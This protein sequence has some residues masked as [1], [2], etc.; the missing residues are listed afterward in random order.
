MIFVRILIL[1]LI[2]VGATTPVSAQVLTWDFLIDEQQVKNNSDEPD[3]ST[4]SPA[5]GTGY[6]EYNTAT[7][8]ISYSVS[9]SNLFGALTKLHVHGPATANTSNPQ[10]LIEI[11]GPPDIPNTVDLH[12]DV[13]TDSHPLLALQQPGINPMTGQP[14]DLLTPETILSIMES[15]EA[16]INVHTTTFGT[17]EIRGN[18][19]LPETIPEP[20]SLYLLLMGSAYLCFRHK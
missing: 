9:W 17:G 20:N 2:L 16:Y 4:N 1:T 11:F 15:G 18:L 13:W 14:Y 12:T 10:H 5:T 3:G 8:V 19:G 6:F 7:N